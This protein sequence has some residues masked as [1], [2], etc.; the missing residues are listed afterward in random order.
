MNRDHQPIVLSRVNGLYNRSEFE[1]SVPVDHLTVADNIAYGERG[2]ETR[3]GTSLLHTLGSIRRFVL[4]KRL[5]EVSRLLILNDA[6]NLYD[7]TDLSTPILTIPEMADFS[8]TQYFNSIYITPHNRNTGIENEVVYVY[9]GTDCRPAGANSPAGTLTVGDSALSG[10]VS[11]GT[12]IV[13]I[14]FETASGYI[15]RPGPALYGVGV[16]DGTKKLDISG[17]PTGPTGTV[18]RRILTTRRIATYNGNQ[19]E[20]TFYFVPTGR[21]ANNVDTTATIDFYD[22][23]LVLEADYLFDQLTTIP[24]GVG[25][26][27]YQKSLVVWGEFNEPSVV[28]V[29]K[30]GEPESFDAVEGYLVVAPNEAGGVKNCVEFRDSL[31]M[32][33][34]QRTYSTSRDFSN[35]NSALFW[36]TISIDEGIGTECFG[37]ASVLDNSGPNTDN[38]IVAAQSGLFLFN[39]IYLQPEFSWKI[40]NLWHEIDRADFDEIQV[41]NDVVSNLIYVLMPDGNLLVGDYKNGLSFQSVRWARWTFPWDITAIAIDIDSDG[42]ADLLLAG[43]GKIWELDSTVHNDNGIAINTIVH[44]APQS[45]GEFDSL[46]HFHSVRVRGTGVGNLEVS[47]HGLDHQDGQD[48]L[49]IPLSTEPGRAYNRLCNFVNEKC[50]IRFELDAFGEYAKVLNVTLFAAE[51]WAERPDDIP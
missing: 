50:A 27:T 8:A 3:P 45:V 34:S 23:D 37:I 38:I 10:H 14:A 49:A 24:A 21:I 32:H 1:D 22:A 4:Y 11:A 13:A 46:G 42:H 2:W 33:K 43:D 26:T 40:D 18:A 20:Y 28:R 44:Y 48:L 19:E 6:G 25:I 30:Q 9:D 41:Y 17:I 5:N 39:G 51:A 31:Y 15:S 7:S 36:R 35:E 16:S 29:S 47:L 12:H